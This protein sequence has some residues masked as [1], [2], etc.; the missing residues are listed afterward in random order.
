MIRF[1]LVDVHFA[2]ELT[3]YLAE[4][5][6]VVRLDEAVEADGM[7]IGGEGL[8]EVGESGG[9]E[10]G[11]ACATGAEQEEAV[12]LAGRDGC[13]EE[14]MEGFVSSLEMRGEGRPIC[15]GCSI[16]KSG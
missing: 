1:I 15:V 12:G 16:G 5:E 2:A 13:V 8:M 3:P 9:Y 10:E 6:A 11:F 4:G 7:E 14:A